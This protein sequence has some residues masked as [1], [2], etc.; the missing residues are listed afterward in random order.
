[1]LCLYNQ[2]RIVR[3]LARSCFKIPQPSLPSLL[4]PSLLP[5]LIPDSSPNPAKERLG[6]YIYPTT[7]LLRFVFASS[8]RADLPF[9]SLLSFSTIIVVPRSF[10]ASPS[11]STASTQSTPIHPDERPLGRRW[12]ELERRRG[13]KSDAVVFVVSIGLRAEEGEEVDEKIEVS[14][15]VLRSNG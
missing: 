13:G 14:Y 6:T 4:S 12:R 11:T 15:K 3:E 9:P 5:F 1:M 10:S 7:L 2:K 8:T